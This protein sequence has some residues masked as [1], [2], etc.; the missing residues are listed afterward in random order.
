MATENIKNIGVIGLGKMGLPMARHMIQAGFKVTGYDPRQEARAAAEA[1]GVGRAASNAE[2]ASQSEFV[3]V[4]VGFDEQV[5]DVLF[6][7]NGILESAPPGLVVGIASTVSPSYVRKLPSRVGDRKVSFI[8]IPIAR[9]E[10]A[11]EKGDLLVF[12]G[13]EKA[14]FE[15]CKP[16]IDTFSELIFHLGGAGAGQ[17]GKA[18]NNMLLWAC[19]TSTVEALNWG[20]ALG[21]EAEPLRQALQYSSGDNWAM[22]TRADE[23]PAL[24]AEKDMTIVLSEADAAR[25]VMPVMGTIKEAIKAFK[26]ARNLPMPKLGD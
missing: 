25:V 2:V 8:D 15:R 24:W 18:A 16:A 17:V 23:R 6:G 26:V 3:I 20:E 22:R 12:A 10:M 11:A 19:L 9:G 5:E 14:D 4:I 7:K 1:V 21:V 13:G